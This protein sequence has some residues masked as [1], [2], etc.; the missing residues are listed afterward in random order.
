MVV[1][2]TSHLAAVGTGYRPDSVVHV[3]GHFLLALSKDA[4]KKRQ[5]RFSV[6]IDSIVSFQFPQ[7]KLITW[8]QNTLKVGQSGNA[9][10]PRF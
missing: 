8:P 3:F 6:V 1:V 4:C 9:V 7:P 2:L 5:R 10:R